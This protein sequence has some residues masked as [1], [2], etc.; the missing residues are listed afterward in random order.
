MEVGSVGEQCCLG[1]VGE[2]DGVLC[3]GFTA[4][5]VFRAVGGFC[6]CFVFSF[7]EKR[8]MCVESDLKR[9]FLCVIF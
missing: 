3:K 8:E 9:A 1:L 4:V 7:Q 2:Q 6:Y 5:Y